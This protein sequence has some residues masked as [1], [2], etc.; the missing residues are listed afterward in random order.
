MSRTNKERA[1]RAA[2]M[3]VAER[4]DKAASLGV[5]M[6]DFKS[7]QWR[8]SQGSSPKPSSSSS[9]SSSSGGGSSVGPTQPSGGGGGGGS[10]SGGGGGGGSFGGGGSTPSNLKAAT[11]MSGQQMRSAAKDAGQNYKQ[12]REEQKNIYGIGG[13]DAQN[14]FA[15]AKQPADTDSSSPATNAMNAGGG[16]T[17][18][19]GDGLQGYANW[20]N[21]EGKQS[22][23]DRQMEKRKNNPTA[24]L[25]KLEHHNIS[26]TEN[27]LF[28]W[29]SNNPINGLDVAKMKEFGIQGGDKIFDPAAYKSVN[30]HQGATT[31]GRLNAHYF[32]EGLAMPLRTD[33]MGGQMD[34]HNAQMQ[35]NEQ[36]ANAP[37]DAFLSSDGLYQDRYA[38]GYHGKD[39]MGSNFVGSDHSESINQYI[40]D[41]NAHRDINDIRSGIDSY[42]RDGGY[43]GDA[44]KILDG[45]HKQNLT[46]AKDIGWYNSLVKQAEGFDWEAENQ[47]RA[48]DAGGYYD[49]RAGG[50]SQSSIQA[51]KEWAERQKNSGGQSDDYW[52]SGSGDSNYSTSS[53]TK[54]T[55]NSND[56]WLDFSFQ[57]TADNMF[58][59]QD[60][61][62]NQDPMGNQNGYNAFAL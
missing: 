9:S 24:G 15:T 10:S 29:N 19:Y 36:R 3:S 61:K 20:W 56:N 40:N 53:L 21:A 5:S 54:G 14:A 16:L 25:S 18:K 11:G 52:N 23:I 46:S 6:S 39:D 7:G 32:A 41:H 38:V 45:K 27:G 57:N 49:V 44:L 22:A 48:G 34:E 51:N 37:T 33:A 60:Q 12:W 13:G 30:A 4:R 47:S 59:E 58:E 28:D 17:G 8:P 42:I 31:D 50:M 62:Q 43:A 1:D 55:D 2:N 26:L 35:W